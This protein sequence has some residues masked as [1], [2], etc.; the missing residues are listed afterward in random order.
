MATMW[1]HLS[2]LSYYKDAKASF[3]MSEI[4]IK[5]NWLY[6]DLIFHGDDMAEKI[7]KS[8]LHRF[9]LELFKLK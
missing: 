3:F 5:I 7:K 4:N 6:L 9:L 1:L 2:K 8:K